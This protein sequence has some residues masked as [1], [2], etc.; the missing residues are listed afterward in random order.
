MGYIKE[1]KNASL[2]YLCSDIKNEGIIIYE[3]NI[4][5]KNYLYYF[6]NNKNEVY[7]NEKGVMKCKG[8]YK[9]ALFHQLFINETHD[10]PIEFDGLKRKHVSLTKNDV[11][12]G[13]GYFS[14]VSNTNSR[15]YNKTKWD[16]MDFKD[17]VWY[18]K[19]YKI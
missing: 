17:N 9:K 13:V 15:T 8:I 1:K 19:G 18:P 3:K 12:N 6:I 7:E 4:A 14:I 16:G 10:K 11:E 2:G 5:P